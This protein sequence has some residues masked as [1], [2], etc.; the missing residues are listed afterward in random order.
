MFPFG[1]GLGF[2]LFS[3]SS[4]YWV[5][6]ILIEKDHFIWLGA[7]LCNFLLLNNQLLIKK[8]KKKT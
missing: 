2:Q 1:L 6:V 5:R 8:K 3:L 4:G 7:N